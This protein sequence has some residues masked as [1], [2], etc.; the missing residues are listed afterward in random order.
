M[1]LHAHKQSL[2]F[3][4]LVLAH[5]GI[6]AAAAA[7]AAATVPLVRIIAGHGGQFVARLDGALNYGLVLFLQPLDVLGAQALLHRSAPVVVPRLQVVEI[8]LAD[9]VVH[10]RLVKHL[11]DV[12]SRVTGGIFHVG[13]FTQEVAVHPVERHTRHGLRQL[14]P[15]LAELTG[16]GYVGIH[17]LQHPVGIVVR[18]SRIKKVTPQVRELVTERLH[19]LRTE[20]EEI[21]A[22]SM[23]DH[24]RNLPDL[25][26]REPAASGVPT[27]LAAVVFRLRPDHIHVVGVDALLILPRFPVCLN[28][29]HPTPGAYRLAQTVHRGLQPAVGLRQP[30]QRCLHLSLVTMRREQTERNG[31]KHLSDAAHKR[32]CS[33][34][35]KIPA[36]HI[37]QDI[38]RR[39]CHRIDQRH[40]KVR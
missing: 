10:H 8:E 28:R 25:V 18:I 5:G 7:L 38:R 27:V 23:P 1:P 11:R 9:L 33:V 37:A 2:E 12:L 34:N 30:V 35:C 29:G 31:V 39:P 20:R 19:V 6:R 14:G 17:F 36:E 3:G 4:P 16:L 21:A 24:L 13:E 32:L 40:H 15:Q 22:E 26:G